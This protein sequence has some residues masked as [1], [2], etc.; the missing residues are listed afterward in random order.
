M[1]QRKATE[2]DDST[3]KMPAKDF[4]FFAKSIIFCLGGE[5][6]TL[7]PKLQFCDK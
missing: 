5:H 1:F 7:L 3:Y 4:F 2:A 6:N